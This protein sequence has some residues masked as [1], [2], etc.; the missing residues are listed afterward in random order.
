MSENVMIALIAGGS[1]VLGGVIGGLISMLTA[2]MSADREDKRRR[3]EI[4]RRTADER[5]ENLY[6]PLLS[7]LTPG[8]PYDEFYIDKEHQCRIMDIIEENELHA[9]PDLLEQLWDLRHAYF[10][11]SKY[12]KGWDWR[13]LNLVS[14]EHSQLKRII[15][16][17]RILKKDSMVKLAIRKLK[18]RI[19]QIYDDLRNQFARNAKKGQ[20]RSGRN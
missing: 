20:K 16:Y 15:G 13:L 3:E 11:N 12:E 17:G 5:L 2:K 9:S 14:S 7:A 19:E 1:A 4:E 18:G 6:A 10:G 8:P